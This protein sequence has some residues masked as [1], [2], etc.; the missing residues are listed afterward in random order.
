MTGIIGLL[1]I[2]TAFLLVSTIIALINRNRKAKGTF[3]KA[4]ITFIIMLIIIYLMPKEIVNKISEE[5]NTIDSLKENKSEEPEKLIEKET[6][7][8]TKD[9]TSTDKLFGSF[10]GFNPVYTLNEVRDVSTSGAKRGNLYITV[11]HELNEEILKKNLLHAAKKFYEQEKPDALMVFAYREGDEPENTYSAAK[12]VVAPDGDWSKAAQNNS[13]DQLKSTFDLSPLYYK[14][15]SKLEVG[16]IRSYTFEEGDW[17]IL[18]KTPPFSLG[19]DAVAFE[20]KINNG[21]IINFDI[22]NSETQRLGSVED[23][24][25]LVSFEYE[26]RTYEGWISE[27]DID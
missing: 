26:N 27:Y 15:E 17:I 25:Y 13:V 19:E 11:P 7:L 23:T 20:I 22:L 14:V 18:Y 2:I 10:D 16:G 4:I 3:T 5:V 24:Y 21:I 12:L 8:E 6:T 9:G 1:G